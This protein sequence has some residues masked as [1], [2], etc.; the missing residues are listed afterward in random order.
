MWKKQ[1]SQCSPSLTML[2]STQIELYNLI[3]IHN[4]IA[5]KYNITISTWG[6]SCPRAWTSGACSSGCS[7][8]LS[9]GCRHQPAI[10]S[11]HGLTKKIIIWETYIYGICGFGI[12][13][14]ANNPKTVF[15]RYDHFS[16]IFFLLFFVLFLFATHIISH[17]TFLFCA[18]CTLCKG[19]RKNKFL[20]ARPIKPYSPPRA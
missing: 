13:C 18:V 1:I 20:V 2:R 16:H 5:D 12:K 7:R 11:F 4:Y 9:P 10:F 14:C 3:L 6:T 17:Y 8:P 19:S 15:A